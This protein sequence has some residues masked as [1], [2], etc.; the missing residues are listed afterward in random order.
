M[1]TSNLQK[2]VYESKKARDILDEEFIEF[3]PKKRNINENK[4]LISQIIIGC[5]QKKFKF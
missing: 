5:Y 3:A 1:E 4:H 2:K